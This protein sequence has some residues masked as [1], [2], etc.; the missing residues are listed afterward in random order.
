MVRDKK[1]FLRG[2]AGFGRSEQVR[3]PRPLILIVCEGECTEPY[4]LDSLRIDLG[5]ANVRVAGKECGSDPLSVVQYALDRHST[6]KFEHIF[7][8][9]DRDEHQSFDEA[10]N[11]VRTSANKGIPIEIIPSYPSF[12]FWYILH[13]QFT[14]APIVKT[15]KTS[16][17]ANAVRLL[18]KHMRRK[19]GYEKTR[20]DMWNH[21][22][23]DM[24]QAIRNS[25]Q[26][27]NEATQVGELNPSTDV[28]KL[29]S[30]LFR[31]SRT[32]EPS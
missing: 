10:M 1:R 12:E 4:Y 16:S 5:L 27:R 9:V 17:G 20:V 2:P 3:D 15:G 18:K 26:A 32:D 22:K 13:F 11:L 31:S 21:L 14:R 8:V 23:Q 7:C 19:G 29:V 28:D 25:R 30:F 6:D 24:P